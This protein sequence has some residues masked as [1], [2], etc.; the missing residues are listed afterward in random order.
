[1]R[2]KANGDYLGLSGSQALSRPF[3]ST[4]SW[5]FNWDCFLNRAWYFNDPC[6]RINQV[7]ER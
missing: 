4:E 5:F 2:Q 3:S 1:M 6:W 7:G